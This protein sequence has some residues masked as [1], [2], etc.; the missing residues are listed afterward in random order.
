MA[1]Q[2]SP[3]PARNLILVTVDTWRADHFATERAGRPLTPELERFA[4]TGVRFTA[5]QSAGTETSPGTAGILTGLLPRRSG[6][7]ANSHLLSLEVPTLAEVL[8]DAGFATEAVVGNVILDRGMGF[9]QGFEGYEIVA[10]PPKPSAREITDAALARVTA[11]REDLAAGR[12]LFLWV[13][14]MDPHGPYLP[15]EKD[16][17]RFPAEAFEAPRSLR[18]LPEGDISGRGGIPSYQQV[19][20]S[21]P[22]R[23]GRRYLAR[24]AAEIHYMDREV[25]RLLRALDGLGVLEDAVVVL[26]ADH[27]EALAGDHGYYFSHGH[28]LTQD[29]IHVPLVVRCP[30][31]PRGEIVDL[32]V[33]TLGIAPTALRRLGV[34]APEGW[35]ADG[36]PLL[37]EAEPLVY[38]QNR[39]QVALRRGFWKAVWDQRGTGRLYNLDFDAGERRDVASRHREV[40]AA[41]AQELLRLRRRKI[42][43]EPRLR[44]PS[45]PDGRQELRAL[46]YL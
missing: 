22:E 38:S 9:D 16:L 29:Q 7:I 17:S 8:H 46:G 32:P 33:S 2:R 6:V 30:S 36:V 26:T 21:P 18:L 39:W 31:C 12:R 19:G 44:P 14:Y 5:A 27:G 13:H 45:G 10:R 40:L 11:R 1:C 41:L 23:D 20:L 42:L 15:P 24:Y 25:S 43:A 3:Q 28:Q 34:P 37:G 35:A 4:D